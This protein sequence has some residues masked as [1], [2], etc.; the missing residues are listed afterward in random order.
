MDCVI[1]SHA[2]VTGSSPTEK[3]R[4]FVRFYLG[5]TKR[6]KAGS[7]RERKGRGTRKSTIENLIFSF[8]S[9]NRKIVPNSGIKFSVFCNDEFDAE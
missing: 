9:F 5:K 7:K 1:A 2:G 3:E 4:K 6:S 8:P